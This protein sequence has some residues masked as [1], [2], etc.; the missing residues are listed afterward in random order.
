MLL[1]KAY[2]LRSIGF[3]VLRGHK[4]RLIVAKH[5]ASRVPKEAM[6]IGLLSRG[7]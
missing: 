7:T 4:D 6:K 2:R 5:N 3:Q 1:E